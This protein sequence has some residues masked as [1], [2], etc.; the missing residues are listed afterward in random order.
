MLSATP[1]CTTNN[2]NLKTEYRPLSLFPAGQ[3][4]PLFTRQCDVVKMTAPEPAPVGP[5]YV[6]LPLF[7]IAQ[8]VTQ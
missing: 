6:Q 4:L 7:D 5:A 8:G 1:D 3:D 2:P